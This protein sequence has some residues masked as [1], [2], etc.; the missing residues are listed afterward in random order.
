MAIAFLIKEGLFTFCKSL[1]KLCRAID[2]CGCVRNTQ[3][4]NKINY[5]DINEAELDK[6][7]CFLIR[8]MWMSTRIA[9]GAYEHQIFKDEKQGKNK[10][11][12]GGANPAPPDI[13]V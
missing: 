5:L 10:K 1:L 12:K 9:G 2:N 3:F 13:S 7:N 4:L 11:G 8:K 6:L